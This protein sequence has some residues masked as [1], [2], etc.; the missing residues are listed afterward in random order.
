MGWTVSLPSPPPNSCVEA[1]ICNTLKWLYLEIG[2]LKRWL[3][4][5]EA[6]RWVLIQSW[7]VSLQEEEIWTHKETSGMYVHRGKKA[8]IYKP[9]RGSEEALLPSPWSWAFVSGTIRNEFLLFKLPSLWLLCYDCP[10]RPV[11]ASL[12]LWFQAP[13]WPWR[14][15]PW[16]DTGALSRLFQKNKQQQ[17]KKGKKKQKLTK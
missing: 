1:L 6:I 13:S 11:L 9:R 10:R 8:V 2:P 4:E 16:F 5:N 12:M 7:L 17:T 14:K 3:G 15:K